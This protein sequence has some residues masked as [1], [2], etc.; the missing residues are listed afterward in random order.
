VRVLVPGGAGFIGSWTGVIL[1]SWA[2]WRVNVAAAT[3][4]LRGHQVVNV[5]TGREISL[6]ELRAA[7]EETMSRPLPHVF[8]P[9]RPGDVGRSCANVTALHN[10]FGLTCMTSLIDGLATLL[11]HSAQEFRTKR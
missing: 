9:L 2:R 10:L 1:S 7:I 4:A 3:T 11:T 6:L 8:A 5:G